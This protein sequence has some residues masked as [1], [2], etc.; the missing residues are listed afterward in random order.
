M[1][2]GEYGAA[3][4]NLKVYPDEFKSVTKKSNHEYQFRF[5]VVK[6]SVGCLLCIDSAP[7]RMMSTIHSLKDRAW[8]SQWHPGAK[9]TNTAA[10]NKIY[11]S[12]Q[13]QT[14]LL[15]LLMVLSYK[16]HRVGVDVANQCCTAAFEITWHPKVKR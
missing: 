9:S 12:Q 6:N 14:K 4:A 2:T 3:K 8:K 7:V 15:I 5:G 10:A 1:G 13:Q 16:I 11:H